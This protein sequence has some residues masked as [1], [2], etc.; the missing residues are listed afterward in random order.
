[1]LVILNNLFV[2]LRLVLN[3]TLLVWPCLFLLLVTVQDAPAKDLEKKINTGK[4]T[5]HKKLIGPFKINEK[6]FT[7]ILK[8]KTHQGASMGFDETVEAFSIV[9]N[10]G[11]V[12]YQKSFGIET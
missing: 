5:N 9:V 6:E 2:K 11:E 10:E 12:H 4:I 7:V 1:M 3:W 8:L